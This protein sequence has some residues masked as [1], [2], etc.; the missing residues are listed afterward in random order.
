M[1]G[2]IH[3]GVVAAD[4]IVWEG[5]AL[6]IIARTTEG[7]VGILPGH[8][9]FL[10]SLVVCA[11]EIL[12]TDGERNV[13]LVD[14][15]YISVS[16]NRVSLLSQYATIAKQIDAE[17]AQRELLAVEKRL[18]EGDTDEETMRHYRRAQAQVRAAQLAAGAS[19]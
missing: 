8:E 12:A 17:V 1:A 19:R 5:D 6:S 2:T 4:G 18:N 13:V 10:A 16:D 15:G 3:V 11:V 7:D 9:P 14:D